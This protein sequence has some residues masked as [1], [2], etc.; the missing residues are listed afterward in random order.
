[1]VALLPVAANFAPKIP[2]INI[3]HAICVS[4]LSLLGFHVQRGFFEVQGINL[5][6]SEECEECGEYGFFTTSDLYVAA[7]HFQRRDVVI[8]SHEWRQRNMTTE[9]Y[10]SRGEASDYLKG[11]GFRVEK[12][13]LAKYAV[14][15]AG[16][17]YRTFGTRVVYDPADLDAWIE[18][19]LTGLRKSTSELLQVSAA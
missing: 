18:R 19:R 10:L 9:R 14:T 13:T 1:M 7:F 8:H 16:P 12:Q 3:F 17:A 4:D 6:N 11:R 15:G 5:E 2:A